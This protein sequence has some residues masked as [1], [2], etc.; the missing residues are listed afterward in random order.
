MPRAPVAVGKWVRC[1]AAALLLPVT[2]TAAAG[3]LPPAPRV[4]LTLPGD[5][6]VLCVSSD[7]CTLVTHDGT[8]ISQEFGPNTG[9]L[10]VWDLRSGGRGPAL[11]DADD[12]DGW[13][14][15]LLSPDGRLLCGYDEQAT[16]KAWDLATGRK[17]AELE[18]A[19]GSRRGWARF[20]P[21]SRLVVLQRNEDRPGGTT[22]IE[23]WDAG[24][25]EARATIPGEVHNSRWATDGHRLATYF[26]AD[27]GRIDRVAFYA[28]AAGD[29]ALTPLA[30]HA[31]SAEGIAFAPALDAFATVDWP[32]GH[33][34]G[35]KAALT[36]RDAT[37]GAVL[38]DGLP[39]ESSWR[40]RRLEWDRQRRRLTCLWID[41]VPT[42]ARDLVT[43][44]E[45]DLDSG[46]AARRQWSV[47][48]SG[49]FSPDCRWYAEVLDSDTS[50]AG[51][52]DGA[53]GEGRGHFQHEGDNNGRPS[54]GVQ[55][56][57]D[58]RFVLVT[59]LH[60]EK[61]GS[62][63]VE[64]RPN[65]RG[66]IHVKKSGTVARLWD[67]EA[68]REV[69]AYNDCYRGFLSADGKTLV[70]LGPGGKEVKVWDVP[71]SRPWRMS[72]AAGSATWALLLAAWWAVARTG[73]PPWRS[74]TA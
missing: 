69:C 49:E 10:R 43:R 4:S 8:A 31:V 13:Y 55:F 57:A 58:S 1:L 71:A 45:Y 26:Y 18:P 22:Q 30:E 52:R 28:V 29:L 35:G 67:V 16:P 27:G 11:E 37:T 39:C 14:H 33:F 25:R 9:T 36:L 60:N 40:L 24:L 68:R 2:I 20:S 64:F 61:A 44:I 48:V 7:G 46:E 42:A 51:L 59:G 70:A 23:L 12:V 32:G 21:D 62:A 15:P 6:R 54:G 41:P 63:S 5:E 65:L 53:G 47:G 38:A 74:Q 73:R 50:G 17:L 56:T 19:A 34:A 66:P 3:V 72:V